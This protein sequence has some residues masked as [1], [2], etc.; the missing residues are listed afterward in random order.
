LQLDGDG[1]LDA[2]I[3]NYGEAQTVWVNDGT[4]SFSA[5]ATTPS[6]GAGSSVD[7]SLGDIDGD[8]DLDTV[9][10]N[11]SGQA[12]TVWV[13][14][15]AGNFGAHAVTPTF[16]VGNS[17]DVPL[18]DID[19][20]GDLDVVVAN[21][22]GEAETVWVND[23]SGSFTAHP[24]TASFGGGNTVDIALDDID[25]DGD[26]D[27]FVA[28]VSQPAALW[29]NNGAG[30]FADSS[31]SF[32]GG[33]TYGMRTGD[34]DGDGDIDVLMARVTD[35]AETVWLNN[36]FAVAGNDVVGTLEDTPVVVNV[37]TNDA[38][39]DSDTLTVSAKTDGTNGTV[40]ITGGGT[41]VTYTPNTNANG[42]DVFTYTLSDGN[43]GLDTGTVTVT[44]TAVNDEPSFTKGADTNVL[45][46][47][48]VQ[49]IVGWAT[50]ISAGPADESGQ[51]LTFT[52]TNDNNGVFSSQ[53]SV[54]ANGTLTYTPAADANGSVNVSVLLGDNGG[55]L[56]GGDDAFP[57]QFFTIT[58]TA[59]NDEPGFTKGSDEN[60]DEDAGAQTVAG[61]AT[62]I[63][64]GPADESGQVL[65]FTLTNDNNGLFSSQPAVAANGTLTYTPTAEASGTAT[66]S[67]VLSDDGGVANGGDDTTDAQ[68]FTITVN[69]VND[70]PVAV[71]DAASTD[72][73]VSVVIDVLANDTD[74]E[75]HSLTVGGVAH[76]VN[77]SVAITGGGLDVTYTPDADWSGMD[78]FTYIVSDG[79][80]GSDT[81]TVVM[82]VNGTAMTVTS[83]V[84]DSVWLLSDLLEVGWTGSGSMGAVDVELWQDANF[85]ALLGDDVASPTADMLWQVR[86]F[87]GLTT[88]DD[89]WVLVVDA[90]NPT[91]V[92]ASEFFTIE[93]PEVLLQDTSGRVGR[94]LLKP[95]GRPALWIECGMAP[96]W[97]M[98]DLDSRRILLQNGDG[99][100]AGIWTLGEDG[101]PAI[102]SRITRPLPG[103]ITRS[104]DGDR[105]LLQ[106]G[107]GG[108]A[109]IWQL[110]ENYL[111]VGW[112][113]LT[114]SV[115]G[116]ATRSLDGD[117]VLLQSVVSGNAGIWQLDAH[118]RVA[119]WKPISISWPGTSDM[120]LRS[121]SGDRLL[122][123]F[124]VG[125][126]IGLWELEE[127]TTQWH[128]GTWTTVKESL[129]GWTTRA[130]D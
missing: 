101:R 115:P 27:V 125:G 116:W 28:N 42:G 107:D 88:E 15:G 18:G 1:D 81:G 112:T 17:Y 94:W 120:V 103:W 52:V 57:E 126:S 35:Q 47:A 54:A 75:F 26:L 66:V 79:N 98:P 53:P 86:L 122:V 83:P 2:V 109:G 80:G 129:P 48:G 123:Q 82:S 62:G 63:S 32:A 105:V 96:G 93:A 74:V 24:T 104:L 90:D 92:A 67:V 65:T 99:G 33:D 76:G 25:G 111:P 12:Q 43:G 77:G 29:L 36:R 49:T 59:V 31:Q 11:Y 71:D 39:A 3:A 38:D 70:A 9:I 22:A 106:Q 102:W 64:A 68:F 8:G 16:G 97:I 100:T 30:V 108:R 117:R 128:L 121:L 95:N 41:N 56:N 13:N 45:E 124:G 58:V 7:V 114:T 78:S 40:A 84:A 34:V 5:H 69:A 113:E 73:D 118:D 6:F 130:L 14:D 72:E 46:D 51:V 55:V 89:Y 23:G 110:N 37:L 91:N 60:V 10:A 20:D 127:D 87:A 4:G 19:G 119:S 61:W 44:I 85:V 21:S 50:G